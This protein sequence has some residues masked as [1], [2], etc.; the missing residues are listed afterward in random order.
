MWDKLFKRL[1]QIL[2]NIKKISN[3]NLYLYFSI[4]RF[5]SNYYS[6]K[7]VSIK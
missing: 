7:K 2:N 5:R 6:E 1:F 3:Y 4:Q